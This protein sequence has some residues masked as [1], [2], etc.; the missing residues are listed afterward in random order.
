[1]RLA[2]LLFT[3]AVAACG[4]DQEL[5]ATG[6]V[7]TPSPALVD[8]AGSVQLQTT[9]SWSDGAE[10][11]ATLT[12]SATGGTISATGLYQAGKIAGEFL[13]IASCTC[14]PV[15]TAAIRIAGPPGGQSFAR[16]AISVSG[17]PAGIP[18]QLSV[19]GHGGYTRA[20][21]ASVTLDSLPPDD[22]VVI[23]AG[24]ATDADSYSPAPDSQSTTLAAGDNKSVQVAYTRAATTGLPPHPRVWMTPARIAQLR[25][26][27]AA[28]TIRWQR[29]KAA[30]DAQLQVNATTNASILPALCLA[31]LGS[32]NVQYAQRAGVI[33]V[34][35]TD[36]VALVALRGDVGYPYRNTLPAISEGLD[37]CYA[38]LTVAQRQRTA[39]WLMDAADW[40][41][42]ESNPT[43]RG[44][45]GVSAVTNNYYWG[46]MMT[47]PAAL[48]AAGD[49]AGRGPISGSDRATYHQQLAL[50]HW[51]SVVLPYL[52]SDGGGGAG[53]EG[54]GY[55]ISGR[56]AQFADAF[57]TAG[58]AVT[59]SWLAQAVQWHL[60]YTM[61]GGLY[62]APLGDQ[63]RVSNAPM[64][65]YN[66]ET[67]LT[68]LA[69][70]N[71]G[72]LLNAQAQRWLALIGQ[73]PSA[74]NDA[75]LATELLYYDPSAPVAAD[76]SGL[77][78]SYF[79]QGAGDFISRQSWTD[80]NAT[81]WVF[82]SGPLRESHSSD[83]AN[84]LMIWKGSFWV[85]AD[86]NIYSQSGINQATADFNNLTV[87]G[88]GQKNSYTAN[89]G[90]IV[91]TQVSDSLVVVRGQAA[92]AYGF[93]PGISTGRSVLRDDLRTVTY[94]PVQDAFVI[95][96]RVTVVDS[97]QPKVWRWHTQGVPTITG[98]TFTL[99]NPA[100]TERCFGTVLSPVDAVLGVQS[101]ALGGTPMQVTSN[102][103]TVTL[104][105][106]RAS[107]VAVTVLQCTSATQAP[108]IP[109]VSIAGNQAIVTIGT[110]RVTVPLD[111]TQS[112]D[113]EAAA[114][115]QDR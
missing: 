112:V 87:G 57:Q 22:Y 70:A 25:T 64:Y 51:N 17:L 52:T 100:G 44:A 63:A 43:R 115:I 78:T 66:R 31:Y 20:L 23:A 97:T 27:A 35:N 36:S 58:Q 71:A 76:L 46:F 60:H 113:V 4:H 26:Q 38:G 67:M 3:V 106:G 45:W 107:D 99:A 95:V 85:S 12:F 90:Q 13:V 5:R 56:I 33:L 16:L 8:T 10:H 93:P 91:G 110:H 84:G 82:E 29:V 48:A 21:T 37:W 19:T 94:L 32:G 96:D 77:P 47:G 73:V 104:P 108:W 114:I 74:L 61:P 81:A 69:A 6:L 55:D 92:N 7:V 50:S 80:P 83:D 72:S 24:V 42:P 40:V 65:I 62:F 41:W 88:N 2:Q 30:A 101:Y 1:M 34:A 75:G 109:T 59:T 14:G 9:V 54:T 89:G 111:E 18:A 105:T 86:A 15:D 39:T 68:T 53:L 28:N 98:N 103:V 49:D 102:A 11:P 79:A